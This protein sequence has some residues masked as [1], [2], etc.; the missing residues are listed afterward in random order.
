MLIGEEWVY[1]LGKLL[2]VFLIGIIDFKLN[3]ESVCYY[4]YVFYLY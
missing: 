3:F 4:F 1:V 2:S